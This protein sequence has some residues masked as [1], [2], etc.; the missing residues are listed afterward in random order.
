[1]P[2]HGALSKAGK[3]RSLHQSALIQKY[4]INRRE[5]RVSK[6]GL[7][8]KTRRKKQIPRLRHRANFH[9]YFI[10]KRPFKNKF[11]RKTRFEATF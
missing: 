6:E 1:M 5:K 4:E 2:T 9:R 11:S 3:V 7:P 10:L 8:R